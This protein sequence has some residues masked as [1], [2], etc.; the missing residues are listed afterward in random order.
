MRR[1]ASLQR[2]LG[3]GLA[4][5]VTVVWIAATVGAG[6]VVRHE[7]DEIFDAALRETAQRL[8]PVAAD[9]ILDREDDAPAQRIAA[10]GDR[11]EHLTYLVR[12][13]AGKVLM[14]SHDVDPSLFPPRPVTGFHSSATHRFYGSSAVSNTLFIE[15]AEPLAHRRKAAFE[16]AAALV[17]PLAFLVPLSLLGVW[18]FVR[19]THASGRRLQDGDRDP[20][21]RRPVA[22]RGDGAARRD[23][24]D[25]RR[26]QPAD[27]AAAARARGRTELHRQQ[28]A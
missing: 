11:E 7:L 5:G 1:A 10:L 13:R 23:R 9:Q 15:V 2:R 3:I 12:N 18:W 28:R 22:G 25:R 26:G 14:R 16:A 20:R 27:R 19:R 4:V 21:Q 8:L 17:L 24:A 6:L